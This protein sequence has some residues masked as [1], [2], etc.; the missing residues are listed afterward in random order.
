MDAG[1]YHG[2]LN[3]VNIRPGEVMLAGAPCVIVLATGALGG[4]ETQG[5]STRQAN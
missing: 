4:C 1:T 3:F 5:P 2:S